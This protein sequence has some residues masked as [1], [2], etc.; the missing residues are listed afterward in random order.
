VQNALIEDPAVA[1]ATIVPGPD[2]IKL[3]VPKAFVVLKPGHELV[4]ARVRA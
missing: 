3:A 2:A 4:P 1:E